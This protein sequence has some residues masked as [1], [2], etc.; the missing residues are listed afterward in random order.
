MVRP[1]VR[2]RIAAESAAPCWNQKKEGLVAVA[3]IEVEQPTE[4]A[5]LTGKLAVGKKEA[6][7]RDSEKTGP[8]MA[9][10]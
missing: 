2:S 9:A 8:A 4:A 6:E 1:S 7:T 10:A 5:E 3:S